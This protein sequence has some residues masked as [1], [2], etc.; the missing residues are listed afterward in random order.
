[1]I[2][3]VGLSSA[4]GTAVV[5]IAICVIAPGIDLSGHSV[6]E[7]TTWA[8]LGQL[9]CAATVLVVS[10]RARWCSAALGCALFAALELLAISVYAYSHWLI[11]MGIGNLPHVVGSDLRHLR[12]YTLVA[13]ATAL[14]AVLVS[15]VRLVRT[16]RQ[17]AVPELRTTAVA[18]AAAAAAAVVIAAAL[19]A[20]A[21]PV[22]RGRAHAVLGFALIAAPWGAAILLRALATPTV[23]AGG[24]AGAF[25]TAVIG[26]GTG[27]PV[28][29]DHPTLG[30]LILAGGCVVGALLPER[31]ALDGVQKATTG[32]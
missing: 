3:N 26:S 6:Y 1:M 31:L 5:V 9:A 23:V 16:E 17:I 30:Y 27:G 10:T 20:V 11:W 21:D 14:A 24:L 22:G 28:L 4:L 8:C 18:S 13:C 25:V 12:Q 19:V 15:A 29:A 32:P 7:A 2:K